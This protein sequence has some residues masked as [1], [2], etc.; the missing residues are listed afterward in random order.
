MRGAGW[1]GGLG[2]EERE[3]RE[4]TRIEEGR[5][6]TCGEEQER[7][8]V[9][10]D[11]VGDGEGVVE[12]EG[13]VGNGG[14]KGDVERVGRIAK[15]SCCRSFNEEEREVDEESG[16]EERDGEGGGGR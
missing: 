13:K 5:T 10:V 11:G 14:V 15:D 9:V 6:C 16:Q 3:G 12:K 1:S 7:E 8:R 4:F 2:R